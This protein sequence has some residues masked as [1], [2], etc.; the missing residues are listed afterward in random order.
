MWW[1]ID[2]ACS[3][4]YIDDL[5]M[6]FPILLL[7]FMTITIAI[8]IIINVFMAMLTTINTTM[9]IYDMILSYRLI[10]LSNP[11]TP[12]FVFVSHSIN[13]TVLP[14][15]TLKEN[16]G[17]DRSWV[18]TT[19]ADYSEEEPKPELLAIRFANSESNW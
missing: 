13:N 8:I 7:T 9:I 12:S 1:V 10:F 4:I 17:S 2:A 19:P 16:V 5:F 3:I 14:S 18:Y 6:I 11:L 15:M